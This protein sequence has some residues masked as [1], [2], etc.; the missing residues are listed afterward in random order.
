[1]RSDTGVNQD[2]N[3]FVILDLGVGL[4]KLVENGLAFLEFFTVGL[5]RLV[6]RDLCGGLVAF[7]A[8]GQEDDR[9][10]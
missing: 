5:L 10:E 9:R 1:M 2:L 7:S 8:G 6:A 3:V 4:E